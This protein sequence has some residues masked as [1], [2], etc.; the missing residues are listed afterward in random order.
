MD[1]RPSANGVLQGLH[2]GFGRACG[3]ILGGALVRYFGKWYIHS[4]PSEIKK[5]CVYR[6]TIDAT[7]KNTLELGRYLVIFAYLKTPVFQK[8]WSLTLSKHLF[9]HKLK[10]KKKTTLHGLSIPNPNIS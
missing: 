4:V 9:I 6:G 5:L 10:K 2:H 3:A 7:M 8:C 1:L